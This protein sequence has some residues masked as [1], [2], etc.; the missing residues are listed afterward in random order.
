MVV[1]PEK[2]H[3]SAENRLL[4]RVLKRAKKKMVE[5][6]ESVV[7]L[8]FS[9]YFSLLFFF[10]NQQRWKVVGFA[11]YQAA[12][13]KTTFRPRRAD[14]QSLSKKKTLKKASEVEEG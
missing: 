8:T 6:V 7:L 3:T 1:T 13:P 11:I 9:F 2:N 12:A 5:N 10:H 14:S 4:L